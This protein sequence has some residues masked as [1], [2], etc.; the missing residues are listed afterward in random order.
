MI[1]LFSI[2]F[3]SAASVVVSNP[4]TISIKMAICTECHK[5]VAE[6]SFVICSDCVKDELNMQKQ[7]GRV[8]CPYCQQWNAADF[9]MESDPAQ[10]ACYKCGEHIS[11]DETDDQLP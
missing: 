7:F 4:N 5:N 1:S 2:L 3:L 9:Y 11:E 8:Q 10:R 6:Q